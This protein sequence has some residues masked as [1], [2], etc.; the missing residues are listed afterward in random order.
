ME[1]KS[2]SSSIVRGDEKTN[3]EKIKNKFFETIDFFEKK[4][5]NK[6]M[7]RHEF[8]EEFRK[9]IENDLI[10][11]NSGNPQEIFDR[12]KIIKQIVDTEK[13]DDYIKDITSVSVI[14]G[15]FT[16]CK[17]FMEKDKIDNLVQSFIKGLD[18]Y[19]EYRNK[20][21]FE[22]LFEYINFK[23]GPLSIDDIEKGNLYFER[24]NL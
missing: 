6:E 22:V 21:V 11:I 5:N 13:I 15:Y 18:I 24:L 12:S 17:Y 23:T 16:A 14:R 1:L 9:K 4:I 10:R 8:P 19:K 2:F 20:I 3:T 7:E